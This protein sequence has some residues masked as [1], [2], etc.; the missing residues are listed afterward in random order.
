M[1]FLLWNFRDRTVCFCFKR[2]DSK[3]CVQRHSLL[4]SL[5]AHCQKV[6]FAPT[7]SLFCNRLVVIHLS[8][9]LMTAWYCSKRLWNGQCVKKYVWPLQTNTFIFWEQAEFT[10]L[11]HCF[12]PLCLY[13]RD[14]FIFA[15]CIVRNKR[16]KDRCFQSSLAMRTGRMS[17]HLQLWAFEPRP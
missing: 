4:L 7:L 16:F 12:F 8:S 13:L 10:K 15:G 2:E 17:L 9:L 14:I 6:H 3:L 5:T 1:S 11:L